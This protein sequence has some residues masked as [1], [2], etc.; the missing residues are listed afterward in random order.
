M[1]SQANIKIRVFPVRDEPEGSDG[2]VTAQTDKSLPCSIISTAMLA[3]VGT[4]YV[5]RQATAVKDA[6]NNTHTLI[7][8]VDLRW[9]KEGTA[10][11][12]PRTFHVVQGAA[13][14]VIL[15]AP[16]FVAGDQSSAG[17]TL[18]IGLHQQ[19]TGDWRPHDFIGR[20]TANNSSVTEEEK[21]A[22][23]RKNQEAA[24]RRAKE[25]E[26]QEKKEAERRA[27][28]KEEQDKKEAERRQQ[29]SQKK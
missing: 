3:R 1:E 19:T 24:E 9:Y 8:Q 11:S 27:K 14:M 12:H 6:K 13:P 15:G 18:P 23:E 5:P 26:E 10:R 29:Q 7:G 20:I 4:E 2:A 16:D 17:Q 22:M 28:E 21:V 25:K